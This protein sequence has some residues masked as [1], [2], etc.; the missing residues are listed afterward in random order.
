MH[1]Y[2]DHMG[3]YVSMTG[4]S[5]LLHLMRKC[6]LVDTLSFHKHKLYDTWVRIFDNQS[7]AHDHFLVKYKGKKIKINDARVTR[8]GV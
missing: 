6:T 1:K 2:Y 5:L 3:T 8:V 7:H 4:Y